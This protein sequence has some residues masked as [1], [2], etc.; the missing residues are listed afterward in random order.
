MNKATTLEVL[1]GTLFRPNET[2][3]HHATPRAAAVAL[4]LV[5]V[6]SAF[7]LAA[8]KPD[9]L[10]FAFFV[11][12]GWVV[13]VWL[14]SSA[15]LFLASRALYR[16]GEFQPISTAVGLAMTPWILVGPVQVLLKLGLP[17]KA[18]AAV[19]YLAI[20]VWWLRLLLIGLRR[21]TGLDGSQA[22]WALVTAELLAVA[23]PMGWLV[24]AELSTFLA[25]A[26][27]L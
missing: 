11:A 23:V 13:W 3:E 7:G 12:L 6:I 1:Y 27:F 26:R 20:S 22:L 25:I 2:L 21:S 8:G 19:C 4:L 16:K 15:G 24:L 5:G 17:G 14:A 10:P 18:L 9:L